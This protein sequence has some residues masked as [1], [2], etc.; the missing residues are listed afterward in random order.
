[1]EDSDDEE[2]YGYVERRLDEIES[3]VGI[4]E[5]ERGLAY[6]IGEK[7]MCIGR[8][9]EGTDIE[10]AHQYILKTLEGVCDLVLKGKDNADKI[11]RIKTL[12]EYSEGVLNR[13]EEIESLL[14]VIKEETNKL[15]AIVISEEVIDQMKN[16]PKPNP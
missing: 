15:E 10:E 11:S 1:M 12:A 2:F 3:A 13:I 14:E 16:N 4:P 7:V 9:L 6:Q 5:Q 8:E